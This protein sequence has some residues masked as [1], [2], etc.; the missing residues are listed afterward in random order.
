MKASLYQAFIEDFDSG[1]S[2]NIAGGS[3]VLGGDDWMKGDLCTE[4]GWGLGRGATAPPPEEFFKI[5][6]MKWR[7]LMRYAI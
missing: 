2:T 6:D 7:I 3:N 4:R 1:G 5:L